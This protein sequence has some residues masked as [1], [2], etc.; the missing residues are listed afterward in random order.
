MKSKNCDRITDQT[1]NGAAAHF[2]TTTFLRRC[3][4]R[5]GEAS[6]LL[7]KNALRELISVPPAPHASL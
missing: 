3:G 4:W 2:N 7:F 1:A 6:L 5:P